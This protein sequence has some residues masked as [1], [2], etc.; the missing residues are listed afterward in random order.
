MVDS[1][2]EYHYVASG[3]KRT[4]VLTHLDMDVAMSPTDLARELKTDKATITKTLKKLEQHGLAVCYDLPAQK[5]S[6]KLSNR[7]NLARKILS[8]MI[9]PK[10]IP[11]LCKLTEADVNEVRVVVKQFADR[12]ESVAEIYG[13][14]NDAFQRNSFIADKIYFSLINDSIVLHGQG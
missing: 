13:F 9:G 6:Y 11:D 7:G 10:T 3:K 4:L 2:E 5:G 1:H 12:T 8:V 14:T